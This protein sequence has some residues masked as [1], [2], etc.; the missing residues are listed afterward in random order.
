M[1]W[2]NVKITLFFF[3]S[4]LGLCVWWILWGNIDRPRR[5][6]GCFDLAGRKLREAQRC[7]SNW[8]R[9]CNSKQQHSSIKEWLAPGSTELQPP[10]SS[11]LNTGRKHSAALPRQKIQ[12]CQH[13]G[14]RMGKRKSSVRWKDVF[15][16]SDAAFF[17]IAFFFMWVLSSLFS[18]SSALT[19]FPKYNFSA[20]FLSVSLSFST[21]LLLYPM[22]FSPFNSL[23]KSRFLKD[24]TTTKRGWSL[25]SGSWRI[26]RAIW[27]LHCCFV[28]IIRFVTDGSL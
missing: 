23:L 10:W 8:L 13:L 26:K 22:S 14:R 5:G 25:G 19:H 4:V 7:V 24:T 3:C 9:V 17:F 12:E 16:F 27:R 21:H 20:L 18:F 28:R 1:H 11:L 2:G 6:R 15:S